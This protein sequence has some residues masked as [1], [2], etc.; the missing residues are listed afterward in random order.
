MDADGVAAYAQT[1]RSASDRLVEARSAFTDGS[2]T[3][4]TFGAV[5]GQNVV[6]AYSRAASALLAQLNAGAQALES[7]S[8]T[9][10]VVAA[11][12]AEGDADAAAKLK[13]IKDA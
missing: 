12:Q 11:S 7:A 10:H 4:G 1:M 5:S 8:D 9:L 13:K 3:T 2:L 6:G